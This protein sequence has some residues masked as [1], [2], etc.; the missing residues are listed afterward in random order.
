MKCI[1]KRGARISTFKNLS[2]NANNTENQNSTKLHELD[3][4]NEM[5]EGKEV[6]ICNYS[7]TK[8]IIEDKLSR[9][10]YFGIMMQPV[11]NVEDDMTVHH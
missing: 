9:M 4:I 8:L 10:K 2:A 7:K 3:K 5:E 1:Y 11:T 6:S